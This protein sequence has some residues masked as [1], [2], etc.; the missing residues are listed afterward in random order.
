MWP[1]VIC[2]R[3]DEHQTDRRGIRAE[4][5]QKTEFQKIR[6]AQGEESR[7]GSVRHGRHRLGFGSQVPSSDVHVFLQSH[8]LRKLHGLLSGLFKLIVR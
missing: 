7:I 1:P 2:L 4:L 8:G 5:W 6:G 3:A